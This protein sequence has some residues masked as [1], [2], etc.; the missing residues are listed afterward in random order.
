[1]GAHALNF[2]LCNAHILSLSEMNAN[3]TKFTTYN[4]VIKNLKYIYISKTVLW[5]NF[6]SILIDNAT[7]SGQFW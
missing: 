4:A 1:M 5:Q 2:I 7:D 6:P 3:I